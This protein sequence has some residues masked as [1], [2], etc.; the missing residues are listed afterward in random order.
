[1]GQ[2]FKAEDTKGDDFYHLSGDKVQAPFMKQWRTNFEYGALE[3][4][5]VLTMP[6]KQ[7]NGGKA[8]EGGN[9]WRFSMCIFLPNDEDGLPNLKHQVGCKLI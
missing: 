3:G 1:L 8:V 7:G 6:Y 9:P 2:T 5:K 4:C